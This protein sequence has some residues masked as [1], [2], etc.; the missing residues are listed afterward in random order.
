MERFC[1]NSSGKKIEQCILIVVFGSSVMIFTLEFFIIISIGLKLLGRDLRAA[2]GI[3][4]I[5]AHQLPGALNN[6]GN[7]Y[8]RIS[9]R[10]IYSPQF[11]SVILVLT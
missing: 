8:Y 9:F 3:L 5:V 2:L 4:D 7:G 1:E 10:A 11:Q 6:L